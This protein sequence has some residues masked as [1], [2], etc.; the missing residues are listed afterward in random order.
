MIEQEPGPGLHPDPLEQRLHDALRA[1]AD[2][3]DLPDLRPA[4]PP[5]R[6]ARF[7]LPAVRPAVQPFV[8]PVRRSVL[9]LL[10]LAAVVAGLLFVAARWERDTPVRPA[11][12]PSVS[13]TPNATEAV[14]FPPGKDDGVDA[15]PDP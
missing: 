13:P 9:A 6:H 2:S 12:V 10:M 11:N 8:R 4:A 5:T 7:R 1:R 14:P 3:V 15:V